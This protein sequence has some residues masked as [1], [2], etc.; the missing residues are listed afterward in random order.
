MHVMYFPSNNRTTTRT[1]QRISDFDFGSPKEAQGAPAAAS[2]SSTSLFD[3]DKERWEASQQQQQRPRIVILAGPH[4]TASTTIQ[5][6]IVSLT[7]TF[8]ATPPATITGVNM[9]VDVT[10][11][12]RQTKLNRYSKKTDVQYCSRHPARNNDWIWPIGVRG[13]YAALV[14]SKFEFAPM[15]Y[16]A[17]LARI[18]T[19]RRIHESLP[20]LR[21]ILKEDAA[22]A[23]HQYHQHIQEVV[24][25]FRQ[26]FRQ[27][28]W[29]DNS[30]HENANN[31][32]RRQPHKNLVMGAEDL[33]GL[34]MELAM[35]NQN[36]D[37][38]RIH[39]NTIKNTIKN[40]NNNNNNEDEDEDASWKQVH[41]AKGAPAMIE[42]LL[43]FFP[44]EQEDGPFVQLEDFEVHLNL[45]IPRYKHIVSTW[46]QVGGTAK[47][48]TTLREFLM[49]RN[50][51][52]DRHERRQGHTHA[53]SVHR[54]V[55]SLYYVNTL[56]AALQYVHYG[57][58]TTIVDMQGV[59]ERQQ[60]QQ[61][62]QPPQRSQ[63]GEDNDEEDSSSSP[64][65]EI[66]GGLEGV[67]AC[68]ILRIGSMGS[69]SSETTTSSRNRQE[70]RMATQQGKEEQKSSSLLLY[71]D[72]ESRLHIPNPSREKKYTKL[73]TSIKNLGRNKC[74]Q[75]LI[76]EQIDDIEQAFQHYDCG[77]WYYLRHYQSRGLLRI[78]YPSQELFA[79]CHHHQ[80]GGNIV[81]NTTTTAGT[82]A[83]EDPSSILFST[84]LTQIQT[85]AARENGIPFTT[86]ERKA[87]NKLQGND[88]S[89]DKGHSGNYYGGKKG[90]SY[91]GDDDKLS[92]S[93][94]GKKGRK[95]W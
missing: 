92:K 33:D 91:E 85:I 79:S 2:K 10:V 35:H 15:K 32:N 77:V 78:L 50:S 75:N 72:E 48:K 46:S 24:H 25:F 52:R 12:N 59:T 44:R 1:A 60:Q 42:Q 64:H 67:I 7:C 19:G 87:R 41:L 81:G 63:Q 37:R 74:P 57:I 93:Y 43:D 84:L 61:Q 14:D 51:A 65:Y 20:K 38:M 86:H 6:F 66:I 89:E 56:A 49:M 18:V 22:D 8:I 70:R 27:A 40:N 68:D 62:Q 83:G 58:K 9:T 45:R 26:I 5:E 82:A 80:S 53:K 28:V 55:A 34:I 21:T 69:S 94:R 23:E 29:G 11:K 71:C 36:D 90:G 30:D 17:P 13:A 47:C 4:K 31:S 3:Y 88:Y 39:N 95:G 76:Q 54:D 73:S 16:Y